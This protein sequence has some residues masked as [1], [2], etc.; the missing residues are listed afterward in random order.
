MELFKATINFKNEGGT[1]AFVQP[2]SNKS[3]FICECAEYIKEIICIKLYERLASGEPVSYTDE[4]IDAL[5]EV[6]CANIGICDKTIFI[7]GL[8]QGFIEP[9]VIN[10][11]II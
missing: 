11:K 3:A 1:V 8:C 5:S 10:V 6:L 2:T 4:D 7:W 9:E